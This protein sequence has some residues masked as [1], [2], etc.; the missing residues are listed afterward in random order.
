V[1]LRRATI[2][3]FLRQ[4]R[5]LVEY[6]I[7]RD[8]FI[9]CHFL[10]SGPYD[11]LLVEKGEKGPAVFAEFLAEVRALPYRH[12]FLD[13]P[14]AFGPVQ[15]QCLLA[16]DGVITPV[17]PGYLALEG[18]KLLVNSIQRCLLGKRE[19]P[20]TLTVVVNHRQPVNTIAA[21]MEAHLR[22]AFGSLVLP[23]AI[24]Y[25]Q[26]FERCAAEGINLLERAKG[27]PPVVTA[28]W[29]L[30]QEFLQKVDSTAAAIRSLPTR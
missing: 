8:E 26:W 7:E 17:Q 15:Q 25:S 18:L 29:Q 5:P 22:Q 30:A 9:G 27:N 16:S 20:V 11:V 10:G 2:E 12:I 28:L 4:G 23:T 24:P 19:G 3:T 1:Q 13:S 6:I 14:P 21:E